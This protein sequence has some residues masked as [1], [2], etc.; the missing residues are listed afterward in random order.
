MEKE[1]NILEKEIIVDNNSN[2]SLDLKKQLRHIKNLIKKGNLY[3]ALNACKK[4]ED[5]EIIQLQRVKILTELNRLDEA[6]K[7]CNRNEFKN[8]DYFI[9]KKNSIQHMIVV[10]TAKNNHRKKKNDLSNNKSI[11][12]TRI[13]CD[14]ITLGEIENQ[15]I[16]VWSKLI[17]KVAYY[18]KIN[19]NQSIFLIKQYKKNNKL[20]SEQNKD[21]NI[22]LCRLMNNKIYIFDP[23]FYCKY[24]N[25]H[26]NE[27]LAITLLSNEQNHETNT[28]VEC[29]KEDSILSN[30]EKSFK[31]TSTIQS[32]SI[33]KNMI[34]YEGKRVNS[35][36]SSNRNTVKQVV[37]KRTNDLLIKDLF[38]EEVLEI[39]K[40]LY[41][42]MSNLK[43]R[44]LAISAWDRFEYLINKPVN[45]IVSL[46]K[47]ISLL[48]RIENST[49][50]SI[51]V[52]EKKYTKYLNI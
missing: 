12:L 15:D 35:R 46:K 49:S 32:N 14:N 1:E 9:R 43:I 41:V 52:E 50:V 11:I 13:Y 17:F 30:E 23:A 47:M 42:Q 10:N 45:D 6:L 24:L 2:E 29:A 5:N 27:D 20:S 4:Y 44:P 28:I 38:S 7:I 39:Q 26:I 18:E 21:L 34:I 19:K 48:K 3:G 37:S 8:N 36:T 16:D 25:C 40:Y 31:M 51:T 22:I 33:S